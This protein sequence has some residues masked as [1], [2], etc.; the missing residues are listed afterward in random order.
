[1]AVAAWA[2]STAFSVGDIRR[3]TT[4]QGSGLWFRCT[5]AG[6]S[7]ANEPTWPT[8]VG[9]TASD[10]T[11]VWTAISATY[12]YLSKVNPSAIIELFLL[13]LTQ[14]E[15]GTSASY[16]FHAGTNDLNSSIV[17][18]GKTYLRLPIVAEGFEYQGNGQNPRPTL[19]VANIQGTI[20]S[21][22]ASLPKGL[23][24]AKVSRIRTMARY[25][26]DVNFSDNTESLLTEGGDFLMTEAGDTLIIAETTG[27]PFGTP[28]SSALLPTEV[29]FINQKKLES[30]DV[31]EYELAASFD[32]QNVRIP[33]RQSIRNICQWKYRTYNDEAF[34]YTHVDCP[35]Q[36]EIYYRA[37]N[38]PTTSPSE[39]VCGKRLDSCK[40]RFGHLTL[41]GQVT[42]DSTAF[43]FD[44]GQLAELAKLDPSTT[45][46]ISGF[47]IPDN[48]NITAKGLTSLTMSAAATGTSTV[49]LN[50]T[51]VSS[52]L[53]IKMVSNAA[54][55]GV[56][57]GMNVSGT[58]VP[59]GTTVSKVQGAKVFL[60]IQFNQEVLTQAHPAEDEETGIYTEVGRFLSISSTSNVSNKDFVIGDNIYEGTRVKS[61]HTN[62]T[63]IKLNKQQGLADGEAV[64][65]AIFEKASR[66]EAT[67]TFTAPDI[68]AIK[69]QNGL[70]FG[71]FPGAGQF[72]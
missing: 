45:P 9:N 37:D 20:S 23:E 61:Q 43:T 31:V 33:K 34:D 46:T 24:G 3:A 38:S 15:H 41:T 54:D 51:I 36:G 10:G 44:E 57:V 32:L 40:L 1:M 48:T 67:Y 29:Y 60:S 65:F 30:R 21:I 5:T 28:D 17:F 50:G 63:R 52:G 69:P 4:T 39:D 14:V 18:D 35:Y 13:E 25:L 53:V 58:M 12:E 56:Q 42:K 62:P 2:A 66:A 6:T 68:Y 49:T 72:K 64:S 47:G 19:K 16:R 59:A 11:V 71:S 26:D 7:S 55:A 70:P 27:N 8:L 22:L